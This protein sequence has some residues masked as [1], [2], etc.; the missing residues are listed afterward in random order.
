MI[1]PTERPQGENVS[2]VRVRNAA[3]SI[4]NTEN[5]FSR[6][7]AVRTLPREYVSNASIDRSS[8]G[9]VRSIVRDHESEKC[10]RRLHDAR[11]FVVTVSTHTLARERFVVTRAKIFS[12]SAVCVLMSKKKLNAIADR[13]RGRRLAGDDE[14]FET[15]PH[16]VREAARPTSVEATVRSLN[17]FDERSTARDGS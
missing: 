2:V 16:S 17:R 3:G 1:V 15:E 5:A 4:E 13:S 8:N 7:V 9:V 6:K 10:P 11:S 14:T 12:P